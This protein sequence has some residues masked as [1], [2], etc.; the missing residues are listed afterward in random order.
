MRA[1]EPGPRLT[2]GQAVALKEA[3][4][5]RGQAEAH[6]REFFESFAPRIHAYARQLFSEGHETLAFLGRDSDL[7]YYAALE[8]K[9]AK[10]SGP[11][12][13]LLDFNRFAL[14]DAKADSANFKAYLKRKG[15][16]GAASVTL[17]DLGFKGS[18]LNRL[19]ELLG[20]HSKGTRVV[21]HL[22]ARDPSAEGDF[23]S[24]EG[25]Q[26]D[27]EDVQSFVNRISRGFTAAL[28]K[29]GLVKELGEER[30]ETRLGDEIARSQ[31]ARAYTPQGG[32]VRAK[33]RPAPR[34]LWLLGVQAVRDYV[35]KAEGN[36]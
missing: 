18:N 10:G 4:L 7:L 17:V 28:L 9:R 21:K 16:L 35:K 34:A 5:S 29:S 26:G 36:G 22:F 15:V 14:E 12:L 6:Y 19:E 11:K 33:T 3:G 2:K 24:F 8:L 13:V 1:P 31:P 30:Y 25:W 32:A 20:E 27:W 23:K